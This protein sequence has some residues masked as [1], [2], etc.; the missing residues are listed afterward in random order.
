[1]EKPLLQPEA[2]HK[3]R[4]NAAI[5]I[6]VGVLIIT[7]I[8]VIYYSGQV[9]LEKT[10]PSASPN[11]TSLSDDPAYQYVKEKYNLNEEQLQILSTVDPN[12]NE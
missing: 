7:G 3:M 10:V 12:D 4:G 9:K 11:P 6:I 8:A 5:L 1:M 2:E